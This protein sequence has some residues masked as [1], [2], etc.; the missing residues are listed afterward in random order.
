MNQKNIKAINLY[1]YWILAWTILYYFNIVNISP[2]VSLT[3]AL[4]YV[5]YIHFLGHMKNFNISIGIG[6][7]LFKIIQIYFVLFKKN[8]KIN[9]ILDFCL[10]LLYLFYLNLNNLSF[11]EIYYVNLPNLVKDKN[12]FDYIKYR[13]QNIF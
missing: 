3:F 6:D 13:I 10:L 1:S 5:S 11:Y 2:I 9:L 12:L 7:L 8:K 4:L